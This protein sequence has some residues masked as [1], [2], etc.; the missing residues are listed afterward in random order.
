[1]DVKGAQKRTRS[2]HVCLELY[3]RI[4]MLAKALT[5]CIGT[6]I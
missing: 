6:W 3:Y 5:F 1:L 2:Q 4:C